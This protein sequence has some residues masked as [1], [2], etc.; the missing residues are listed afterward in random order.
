MVSEPWFKIWSQ[1]PTYPPYPL[2]GEFS[3]KPNIETSLLHGRERVEPTSDGLQTTC[4]HSVFTRLSLYNFLDTGTIVPQLT[5][6]LSSVYG[7]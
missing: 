5:C 7:C 4:L 1:G 2:Y 6:S 3:Q